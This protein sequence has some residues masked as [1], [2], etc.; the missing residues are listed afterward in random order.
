M[1]ESAVFQYAYIGPSTPR[2]GFSCVIARG[3]FLVRE[4]FVARFVYSAMVNLKLTHLR[5]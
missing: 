3:S 4:V 5:S 2:D 1:L